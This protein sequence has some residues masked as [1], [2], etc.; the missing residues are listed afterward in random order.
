MGI[1]GGT[2]AATGCKPELVDSFDPTKTGVLVANYNGGVG[3]KWLEEMAVRFEEEYKDVSFEEGKTGV[4]IVWD[5]SKG[6]GGK[7]IVN[8][9]RADTKNHVFFTQAVDYQMMTDSNLFADITDLVTETVGSDGKKIE[10]KLTDD[11][12]DF[13]LKDGK[14]YAIPHY[15]LYNGIQYDAG[16]FLTKKLYFADA[17]NPDGT[18][19]FIL[20]DK[21]KKS[22]GPDGKYNTYDD[23]LPSS[24]EEFYRV[25]ERMTSNG[26]I[27][28]VW[29]GKSTHYTNMLL[30][31]LFQE[32]IGADGFDVLLNFEEKEIEVVTNH[33]GGV[34]QTE[35]QT[36]TKDTA[37]KVKSSAAMYYALEFCEKIFK[38]DSGNYPTECVGAEYTHLDAQE[39]LWNSGLDGGDYVAMLI[40]GN[41]S[42]NE[43]LAD[44]IFDRLKEDYPETYQKK[45][46]RY[47]PLPQQYSGTVTEGN[48]SSP[49]LLDTYMSYAFIN[50]NTT[51]AQLEA[52]KA[53]LS[54]AYTDEELKNFTL[55]TNGIVKGVSYDLTEIAKD[56]NLCSNGK[57]MLQIRQ[58]AVEG[59]SLIF[60]FNSSRTFRLNSSLFDFR[61]GGAF[62]NSKQATI[63]Y[64]A[65]SGNLTAATYFDEMQWTETEW[66]AIINK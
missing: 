21:T 46:I 12:K 47:M 44:G 54:F 26:V 14:Y 1:L 27:P 33:A 39:K 66:S 6:H 22:C 42:Y 65:F 57:N 38:K 64:N 59:N 29:T 55:T 36:L 30:S 56:E 52:A 61:T 62:W 24:Y 43:A 16:V 15:E 18:R 50:A 53:F 13:L 7:E 34:V 37:Y 28:F 35:N 9:L 51:G 11:K 49:V 5:H 25:I 31:V 20:N 63:V 3:E 32:Y 45:D 60:P 2:L 41:Y 10:K 19:A 23:G 58:A 40:D 4:D 17:F 48:G 8:T